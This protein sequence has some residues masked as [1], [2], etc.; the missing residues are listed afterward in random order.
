MAASIT[1]GT[2][3]VNVDLQIKQG[4]TFAAVVVSLKNPDGTPLVLTDKVLSGSVR[5]RFN[6]AALVPLTVDVTDA[7]Q[8]QFMFSIPAADTVDLVPGPKI[9][10]AASE[11]VWDLNMLDTVSEEIRPVFYGK[12]VVLAGASG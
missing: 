2:L 4:A 11:F 7:A 6:D 3:G 1:L 9:T 8:G 5:R 12:A 10:D